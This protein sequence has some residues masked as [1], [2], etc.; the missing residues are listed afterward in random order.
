M[1]IAST[2]ASGKGKDRASWDKSN[3]SPLEFIAEKSGTKLPEI[4]WFSAQKT[5]VIE[6]PDFEG[7]THVAGINSN[8]R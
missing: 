8:A 7:L 4:V 6:G 3:A 5:L 1:I 2:D